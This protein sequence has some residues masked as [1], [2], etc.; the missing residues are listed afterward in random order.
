[1]PER[2][3]IFDTTLRDGE[4]TPG[5]AL[6]PED[7][8]DI[9]KQLDK[10]GV[11]VIEAGFPVS[12]SGEMT[13]VKKIAAEGLHSEICAL[14]RASKKDIDAT[15]QCDV[16]RI[17]IFIATSATHMRKKLKLTQEEVLQRAVESV[18]YAKE[19]GVSVEFSAE[20]ATRS[21]EPF[22]IRILS[23]VVNAGADRINVADTVGFCVPKVIF[24]LIRAIREKVKTPTSVHCHNDLGMAVA[25]SLAAVEAGADQAHVTVNGIGERTG[26]TS[27]EEL[28]VALQVLYGIKSSIHLG[29]IFKTSQLVS[30][31][32][33]IPIPQNKAVVGENAFAHESGIHTHGVLR[34]PSTYEPF[35]PE[36]VGMRRRLVAG[37]HAGEHGVEAML[38]EMGLTVSTEEL[39]QILE[40]VKSLGDKGRK[41][42]ET[43]LYSLAES[44][45]GAR[46]HRRDKI[47]LQDIVVVTGNKTTPT[48]MVKLLVDGQECSSS[49]FGIGP[50]DA[51]INAVR[52]VVK[53]IMNFQLVEFRL[54][55]I[56]GGTDALA[57]V[58]VKLM[59]ESGRLVS[60]RAVNEDIVMAGVQA[61]INAA[62][63]LLQ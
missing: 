14:A 54:E 39:S 8:L 24:N 60:G 62:N 7:K 48:A 22:L 63:R 18:G 4:Q 42:T 49:N 15:L 56:T 1:L 11:D 40:R 41:V 59:S 21:S 10:L 57:D 37:K 17:H 52:N 23:A 28:A 29:E 20:D 27:L 34:A 30:K 19:H 33:G 12:S 51:S 13:A 5:V 45:I 50:V 32:T 2:V 43:D 25:N 38:K 47:V 6:T 26:N 46:L 9:A 55:S 36:L 44:I 31:L 16:D 35:P 3:W 53:G 61:I 58:T